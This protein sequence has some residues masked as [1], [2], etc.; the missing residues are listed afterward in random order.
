MG[1]RHAVKQALSPGGTEGPLAEPKEVPGSPV[2]TPEGL[3]RFGAPHG[4]K[5]AILFYWLAITRTL[6]S[7]GRTNGFSQ[8][9]PTRFG[10]MVYGVLYQSE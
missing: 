10:I 7:I 2:G 4:G 8:L 3:G 9:Y 6:L 5:A 1:E